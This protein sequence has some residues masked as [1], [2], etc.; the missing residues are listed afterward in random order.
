LERKAGTGA[1]NFGEIGRA[2]PKMLS[3]DGIRRLNAPLRG[4]R[5]N[6]LARLVLQFGAVRKALR[7]ERSISEFGFSLRSSKAKEGTWEA[8]DYGGDGS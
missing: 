5:Q 2:Q 8:E 3:S 6:A 1:V 7:I 4:Q